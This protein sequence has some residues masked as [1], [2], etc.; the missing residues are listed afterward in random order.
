MKIIWSKSAEKR[1][2]QIFDWYAERSENVAVSFYNEILD[3]VEFLKKFPLMAPVESALSGYS[4]VYRSLLIKGLF[5]V[6]YRVGKEKIYIVTI[7]DCR[8][9]PNSLKDESFFV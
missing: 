2:N 8:Q 3:S 6:I 4:N 7:W 5:K 1:L 9:N